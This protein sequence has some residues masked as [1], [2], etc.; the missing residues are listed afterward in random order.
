MKS[1]KKY[2]PVSLASRTAE[3]SD[4]S[5]FAIATTGPCGFCN[6]RYQ[7]RTFLD[8]TYTSI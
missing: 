3:A 2:L 4:P 6:F 1:P 7:K 8:N 5:N